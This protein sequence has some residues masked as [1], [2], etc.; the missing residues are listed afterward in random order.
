VNGTIAIIGWG[1]LIWDKRFPAFD[2]H[3]G[4]WQTAG[5]KILL[6]FSRISESRA[7]ALTL[8]IDPDHG[9]SCRVAYALSKRKTLDDAI[10]DLRCREGTTVKNVG[11]VMADGSRHRG[12]DEATCKA[13]CEWSKENGLDAVVWTDLGSNFE[14]KRHKP[15][16]VEAALQYVQTLSADGKAKA[17]EYVWR[18]PDFVRTPLRERLQSQ[19]WFPVLPPSTEQLR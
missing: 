8:V 4:E 3:H 5:P 18:A 17:A 6:E 9:T 10:C 11:F 2:K 19:P 14:E 7:G 15:F 13:V 16:D 1:S 12:R